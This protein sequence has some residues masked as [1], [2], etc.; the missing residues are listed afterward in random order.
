M[1]PTRSLKRG[2]ECHTLRW[3]MIV[4]VKMPKVGGDNSTT[5]IRSRLICRQSAFYDN[6]V[7]F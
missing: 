3:L 4:G 2:Q 1:A 5:W 6:P 7:D